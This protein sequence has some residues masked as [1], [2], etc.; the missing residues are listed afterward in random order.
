[1]S[2]LLPHRFQN[3]KFNIRFTLNSVLINDLSIKKLMWVFITGLIIPPWQTYV[4]VI[5]AE[6]QKK[7]VEKV[8][9]ELM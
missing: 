3:G 5:F 9:N 4:F 6:T 8:H 2:V 1:M 7:T